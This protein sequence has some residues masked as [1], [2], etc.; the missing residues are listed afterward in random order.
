M[1]TKNIIC[2]IAGILATMS[3]ANAVDTAQVKAACQKNNGT[4]WVES[5][6]SCIPA[7]PCDT[8]KSYGAKYENYC[9]RTFAGSEVD[10]DTYKF[11]V[12]VYAKKH[13]LD[14]EPQTTECGSEGQDF[15]VCNGRDVIVFEF[16][17]ICD[18]VTTPGRID[19]TKTCKALG[20]KFDGHKCVGTQ[21]SDCDLYIKIAE[22]Y[23]DVKE[24]LRPE[25][26]KNL[27]TPKAE[28]LLN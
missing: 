15:V 20:T 5:T 3:A 26:I 21:E 19:Y 24:W 16:D 17:D 4:L 13:G 11:L 27:C 6:Q 1:K 18:T 23:S 9:N 2:G 14:C 12:E 25:M 22:H 7:N 8:S 28:D 10:G